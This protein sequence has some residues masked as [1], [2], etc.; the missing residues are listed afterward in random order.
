MLRPIPFIYQGLVCIV[1]FGAPTLKKLVVKQY[2]ALKKR[3]LYKRAPG[4]VGA[5]WSNSLHNKGF[6]KVLGRLV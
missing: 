2:I 3:A 1:L 4:K 6:L 5:Q